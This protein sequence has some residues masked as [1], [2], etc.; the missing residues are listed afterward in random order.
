MSARPDE[1]GKI[2]TISLRPS[3]CA[4]DAAAAPRCLRGLRN[5]GT[6]DD[7]EVFI[8]SSAVVE[9]EGRLYSVTMRVISRELRRREVIHYQTC[10][11]SKV[12]T[13]DSLPVC[14]SGLSCNYIDHIFQ[15]Q[16]IILKR[17]PKSCQCWLKSAKRRHI[18]TPL[19]VSLAKPM[20]C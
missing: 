1:E 15:N 9:G 4:I 3:A 20:N 10:K 2:R 5:T 11:N 8:L 19:R 18:W 13:L 12:Y 7:V 14:S 17:S 6:F 16:K